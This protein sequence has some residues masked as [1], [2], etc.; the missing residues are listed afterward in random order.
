M[1]AILFIKELAKRG[2]NPLNGKT[3]CI[4]ARRNNDDPVL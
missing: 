2:K 3:N 4:K 1:S